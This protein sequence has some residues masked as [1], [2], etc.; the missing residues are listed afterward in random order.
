MRERPQWLTYQ[1]EKKAGQ[2]KP[3]K[4]PYYIDGGRRQGKQGS[5]E[6]RRRLGTYEQALKAAPK[7]GAGGIGFAFLPDD[8]LIGIDLDGMIDA[9]TGEISER[10][11]NIIAACS[12]YTEYSPSGRGVHI[13]AA[14]KT[15]TFKNNQIGV[16]VFC[17][18]QFFTVTGRHYAGTPLEVNELAEE[19]LRRLRVTVKGTNGGSAPPSARAAEDELRRAEA[20]LAY[21][22]ADAY[23]QWVD[24]GH[25]LKGCFGEAGF[26][27]WDRWSSKSP[28][29]AADRMGASSSAHCSSSRSAEAGRHRAMRHNGMRRRARCHRRAGAIRRPK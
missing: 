18:A 1:Y 14:G 4:V 2:A 3:A 10:G 5:A 24:I 7:N 17:G 20:A 15:R 11:R 26:A 13:Y 22:D 19:V 28:R 29:Y 16:E 6:D 12:T 23:Q 27:L 25:V 9:E 8:G 21:V